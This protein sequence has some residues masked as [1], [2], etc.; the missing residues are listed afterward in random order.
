VV[1]AMSHMWGA[2]QKRHTLTGSNVDD[3]VQVALHEPK[4]ALYKAGK[5]QEPA[6]KCYKA[7]HTSI[8]R[9]LQL[10]CGQVFQ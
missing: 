5:L 10:H 2:N 3:G 1:F 8:K 6:Y 4:Q 7:F 9:V